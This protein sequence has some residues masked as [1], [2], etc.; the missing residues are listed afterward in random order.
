MVTALIVVVLVA[1]AVLVVVVVGCKEP[2]VRRVAQGR[3]FEPTPDEVNDSARHT[4]PARR[5]RLG[6]SLAQVVDVIR[7]EE[8]C[9]VADITSTVPALVG[10]VPEEP[11]E[12]ESDEDA[13]EDLDEEP[14]PA[15]AV[16][17]AF[18]IQ[19][20]PTEQ[21]LTYGSL[22]AKYPVHDDE[23]WRHTGFTGFL[24]RITD[25]DIAAEQAR[26][27]AAALLTE[28]WVSA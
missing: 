12:V 15:P 16:R 8:D 14:E 22:A 1:F 28:A 7:V 23:D 19:G 25:E 4:N 13:A 6:L 21:A 10:F 20:E 9:A 5:P 11:D 18:V 26:H 27:D 24:P 2:V 3:D 17:A